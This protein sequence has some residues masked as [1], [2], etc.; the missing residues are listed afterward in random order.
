M[1]LKITAIWLPLL[2]AT[3]ASLF[4]QASTVNWITVLFHDTLGRAPSQY[5]IERIEN[6][7]STG[8]TRTDIGLQVA[9]SVEFDASTTNAAFQKFLGRAPGAL[10][11]HNSVFLYLQQGAM[12]T[13]LFATLLGTDEYFSTRGKN[14]NS[15]WID[16]VYSDVLNRAPS[17]QEREAFLDFLKQGSTRTSVANVIVT[18]DE[19]RSDVVTGLY[20]TYLR[21][22]PTNAE[23]NSA[24]N[25]LRNGALYDQIVAQILGTDEYFNLAQTIAPTLPAPLPPSQ[26]LNLSTRLQVGTGND[27]AIAGFIITGTDAK[28]I[29]VRGIGP[30][31]PVVGALADPVIEL[32]NAGGTIGTNDNWKDSQEAAIVATGIPP[33]NPLE[34][35]LVG[36]LPANNAA[37]TVLLSGKNG[38]TGVGLLEAYDLDHGSNSRLANISTRALVGAGDNRMIGGVIVGPSGSTGPSTLLIRALGP[39]L[40]AMGIADA[41]PDPV[42]SLYDANGTE[43]DYNDN[44]KSNDQAAI[45]ATTIPP[46]NDLEAAIVHTVVPGNYTAVVSG[47]TT[48]VAQVE[49]YNLP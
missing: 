31:L 3:S 8:T 1:K 49:I 6:Q 29:I 17:S 46:T 7:L 38:G 21:R 4:A 5:E 42:L 27:I 33:S 47:Q 15:T 19:A 40:T 26:N 23:V 48:G 30:S 32:R 13:T 25:Q 41:L 43:I 9:Q 45:E 11:L 2:I 14:N 24:L 44:W 39:S 10:E 16:A 34:S 20:Q 12:E 18:S 22:P 35:A 37:Y 28:Q 36:T